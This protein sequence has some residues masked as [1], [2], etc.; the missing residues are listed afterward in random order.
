MAL[1]SGRAVIFDLD[2]TLTQSEEGIFNCVRHAARAV[3][4]PVPDDTALREYIGPPLSYSFRAYMG[5]DDET[6]ERAIAAFRERYHRVGLFENRV[7]PG[8]R[9]LLRMLKAR[10]DYVAVATGKHGDATQRILD[11]FGLSPYIDGVS[12]ATDAR[13]EKVDI[14]RAVLPET[15]SEAWMVGDRRFDMEGGKAAGIRTIGAGYGYGTLEELQQAGADVCVESVQALIGFLC[16]GEEPP[17]GAFLS[18]EGLDGSGKSTQIALLTDALDRWGFEVTHSREPGGTRI[19]EMLREII[20]SPENPEMAAETEALLYAAGRAQHVR[21]LI[22][23]T[24]ASGRVLLC[25][26]YVDSSV[27]YQ[28]GGRQLGVQR[29]LDINAMAVDGTLPLATVYLDINHEAALKRRHAATSPDRIEAESDAFFAR[30]EQAY[31]E[32]IR[33]DPER[34]IVVDASQP[35]EVMGEEIAQRVIQRLVEDELHASSDC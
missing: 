18:I 1:C 4:A 34:F 26:R 31:R 22:R 13:S 10:G 12:C 21:E 35:P 28:G 30:V 7:Y 19:G 32:L 20:L 33:R 14:I 3:G 2:G 27:A 9:R 16:P 15:C 5:L 17:R 29:V 24:V 6:A 23:P 25:D 11:H 8:I